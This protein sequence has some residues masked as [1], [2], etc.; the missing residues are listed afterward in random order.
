MDFRRATRPPPA[1]RRNVFHALSS[2]RQNPSSMSSTSSRSTLLISAEDADR[3][4][5]L[6]ERDS[7]GNIRLTAPM[8]QKET[9]GEEQPDDDT[10]EREYIKTLYEDYSSKED[11]LPQSLVDSLED[12]LHVM[13]EKKVQSLED[14]RWMFEGDPKSKSS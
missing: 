8:V 13:L 2:R 3:K 5:D 6:V 4:D 1:T 10:E 12:A 14:D 9:A 7:A 11:T